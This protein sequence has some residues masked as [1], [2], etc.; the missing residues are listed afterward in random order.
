MNCS[1]AQLCAIR[2]VDGELPASTEGEFQA[3]I[4]TCADCREFLAAERATAKDANKC[5]EELRASAPSLEASV[6]QGVDGA[7]A[8]R[9]RQVYFA[10]AMA[11]SWGPGCTVC[12]RSA[13]G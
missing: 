12:R 2:L 7:P 10:I 8:G 5:G 3:H 4:E 1:E 13:A 9:P 11:A 6:L